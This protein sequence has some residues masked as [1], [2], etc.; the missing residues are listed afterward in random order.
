MCHT[1]DTDQMSILR[2]L[3]YEIFLSVNALAYKKK[4]CTDLT[5][6]ETVQERLC[7]SGIRTIIE[8]ERH[9]FSHI[10][11]LLP[12]HVRFPRH[13]VPVFSIFLHP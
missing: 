3:L 13:D 2:H 11:L 9:V 4:G 8:C 6:P 1:M 12:Y 10:G 7:V 5:F